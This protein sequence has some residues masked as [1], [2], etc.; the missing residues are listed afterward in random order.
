MQDQWQPIETCPLDREV[1]FWIRPKRADETYL[2]SAGRPILATFEPFAQRTR[3]GWW[4]ALS[5]SEFWH[6]D[7]MPNPP[8]MA[9]GEGGDP[10]P[11]D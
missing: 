4:S 3:Y 11:D 2:D 8:T 5:K 7:T 10:S 1:W 6:E 9:S